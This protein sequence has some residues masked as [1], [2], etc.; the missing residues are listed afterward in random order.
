VVEEVRRDRSG[1]A[2]DA[3][4]VVC[5]DEGRPSAE[6]VGVDTQVQVFEGACC[7]CV[8]NGAVLEACLKLFAD[9]GAAD[10]GVGADGSFG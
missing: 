10:G 5:G 9:V 8:A 7:W 6:V 4:R 1:G 3:W 2:L